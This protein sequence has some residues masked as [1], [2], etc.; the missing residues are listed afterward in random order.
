MIGITNF[1]GFVCE[2]S[3]AELWTRYLT[4]LAFVVLIGLLIY[5][6]GIRRN[7]NKVRRQT[8][9]LLLV[10]MGLIIW[11]IAYPLSFEGG[12]LNGCDVPMFEQNSPEDRQQEYGPVDSGPGIQKDLEN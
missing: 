12:F 1:A 5:M 11:H 8:G 2:Y 7:T 6:L 10:G 4:I 3:H 9:I